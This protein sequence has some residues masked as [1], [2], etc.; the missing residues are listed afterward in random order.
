MSQVSL[1]DVGLQ[2]GTLAET[3]PKDPLEL[4]PKF[5][6][7][8][9]NSTGERFLTMRGIPLDLAKKYGLGYAEFGAWP[10]INGG[11]LIKQT[12][13][14]RLVF[15]CTDP[16]GK[17]L[18]LYGRAIGT[19]VPI[20]DCHDHL[21]LAKKGL[22]N[23]SA[24][25][26]QTVIIC[27]DPLDA[28]TLE[29]VGMQNVCAIF[30]AKP[31]PI[32]IKSKNIIFAEP[33][34][35]WIE[36]S[37]SWAQQ[38]SDIC[39]IPEAVLGGQ[40]SINEAMVNGTLQIQN[41]KPFSDSPLTFLSNNPTKN[42]LPQQSRTHQ[43]TSQKEAWDLTLAG[44]IINTIRNEY[45]TAPWY[46]GD[47]LLWAESQRPDLYKA[48]DEA[49][50]HINQSADAEDMLAYRKACK[51]L[52]EAVAVVCKAYSEKLRKSA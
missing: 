46:R 14:G 50:N 43:L 12:K 31:S 45:S 35:Q 11:S 37:K 36:I 52:L 24:V 40:P 20:G 15:P 27:R 41:W 1:F 26:N 17:L 18:N 16:N 48:W 32:W 29:A 10:H 19:D 49:V 47:S 23:G 51:Q 25:K 5:Q 38:G 13:L 30:D 9:A 3:I 44:E 2:G 39:F 42:T 22:F 34:P 33:I 28:L 4:L 7:A 21:P 8:L 6:N